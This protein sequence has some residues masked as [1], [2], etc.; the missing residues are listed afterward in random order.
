MVAMYEEIR[1]W[2]EHLLRDSESREPLT[3]RLELQSMVG[4]QLSG[5]ERR[6]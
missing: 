6:C 4:L 3:L 1:G 2:A 5:W